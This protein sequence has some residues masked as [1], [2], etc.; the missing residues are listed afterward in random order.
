[1]KGQKIKFIKRASLFIFLLLLI[2][3]IYASFVAYFSETPT[4]T[5]WTH[6]M[7][8]TK[9]RIALEKGSPKLIMFGGSNVLFGVS[10]KEAENKLNIPTMNYASH[11]DVGDYVFEKIKR[12][13]KP[14]DVIVMALEYEYYWY[15]RKFVFEKQ[16]TKERYILSHDRD[17]YDSLSPGEKLNI[18]LVGIED[19]SINVRARLGNLSGY[20][21]L[22]LNEWGDINNE[23]FE[24]G[25]NVTF[26]PKI[27]AFPDD[28]ERNFYKADGVKAL[29]ELSRWSRQNNITIIAS[30]PA[31]VYFEEYDSPDY[32][33]SFQRIE[34]FYRELNITAIGTPYDF[35]YDIDNFYDTQYHLNSEYKLNRTRFLASKLRELGIPGL[36]KFQEQKNK[37]SN[38]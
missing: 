33:K 11:A 15:D 8:Q 34:L 17:Y 1:M 25:E 13:S 28:F 21:P 23:S 35:F 18:L 16:S 29:T 10:A 19:L 32:L 7:F 6:Q 22:T 2:L 5:S 24:F 9:D 38:E 26:R 4:L 27:I 37:H 20:Y 31:T 36:P 30:F 3:S 12:A 14:G